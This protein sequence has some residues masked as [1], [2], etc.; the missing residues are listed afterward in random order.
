MLS[1]YLFLGVLGFSWDLM[2]SKVTISQKNRKPIFYITVSFHARH[3]WNHIKTIADSYLADDRSKRSKIFSRSYFQQQ[4]NLSHREW[5]TDESEIPCHDKNI[6]I[7][8]EV[9]LDGKCTG[10]FVAIN[11]L[12]ALVNFRHP[13]LIGIYTKSVN[14]F[15]MRRHILNYCDEINGNWFSD[16]F[17]VLT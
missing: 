4:S 6:F 7:W 15:C 3:K 16:S 10:T 9:V 14:I 13:L 11:Q 8:I 17:D 5:A 2:K 12:I 1:F